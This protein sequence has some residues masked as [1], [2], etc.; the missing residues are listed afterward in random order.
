[1][2]YLPEVAFNAN[3][4]PIIAANNASI[5]MMEAAIHA[6]FVKSQHFFENVFKIRTVAK[7]SCIMKNVNNVAAKHKYR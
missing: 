1:M 2:Y 6:G 7:I 5:N 4:V 3:N